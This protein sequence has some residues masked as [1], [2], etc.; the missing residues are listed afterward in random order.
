MFTA[1]I[2]HE[3]SCKRLMAVVSFFHTM[4]MREQSIVLSVFF[5]V[6]KSAVYGVGVKIY[7]CMHHYCKKSVKVFHKGMGSS[8]ITKVASQ[9]PQICTTDP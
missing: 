9:P 1:I 5:Y 2:S 4:A 6:N 3:C 8:Y 7:Q